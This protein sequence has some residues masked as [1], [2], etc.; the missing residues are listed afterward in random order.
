MIA[1]LAVAVFQYWGTRQVASGAA[2]SRWTQTQWGPLG[3]A[4]RDMLIKVRQA[5]LWEMPTGQQAQQQASSARVREVGGLIS[6][7][8]ADLDAQVRAVAAQLGVLLPNQ[9]SA[10][11]QGWMAEIASQSGSDFDRTFVQRL[12]AAHGKVLPVLAVVRA[13]TRNELVRS[14]ATTAAQ[15]VTR[16]HEYLESTGLVDFS[17]LPEPPAPEPPAPDPPAADP[18]AADP[19]VSPDISSA[20][21][22]ASVGAPT[23]AADPLAGHAQHVNQV[24]QS[25]AAGGASVYVAALVYIAALL[26][27]VGLLCLLGTAGLRARQNHVQLRQNHALSRQNHAPPRRAVHTPRGLPPRPRH[28]AQRW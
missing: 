7:E 2:P 23:A 3:P 25:S 18:P 12:R 27:I 20:A 6:A 21:A 22:A 17:A 24:A 10:Q 9:P 5:G 14:F 15:F 16:H 4:D 11:Q 1:A 13:G 19:S 26:A 8:H 28:A